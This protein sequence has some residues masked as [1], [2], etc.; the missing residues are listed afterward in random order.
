MQATLVLPFLTLSSHAHDP[1]VANLARMFAAC[2]GMF[3]KEVIGKMKKGSYLVNNAR[4]GIVDREAV[5]EACKS[6]HL[7]GAASSPLYFQ[8]H[9]LSTSLFAELLCN[10][11]FY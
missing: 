9:R 11:E 7:A 8:V 1:V 3:S 10:I 4:G 5:L 2:R 6:G